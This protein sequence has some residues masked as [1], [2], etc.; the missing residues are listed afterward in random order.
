MMQISFFLL[1]YWIGWVSILIYICARLPSLLCCVLPSCSSIHLSSLLLLRA[2]VHACMRVCGH[3]I[4]RPQGLLI[5]LSR[6][7]LVAREKTGVISRLS[8][9]HPP[10][11][12]FPAVPA[13]EPRQGVQRSASRPTGGAGTAGVHHQVSHPCLLPLTA[14]ISVLLSLMALNAIVTYPDSLNAG[15]YSWVVL[16]FYLYLG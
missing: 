16:R 2:C 8:C 14:S 6:Y 3:P 15:L 13:A 4:S 1:W 9:H 7:F 5:L 10:W 11:R 12:P